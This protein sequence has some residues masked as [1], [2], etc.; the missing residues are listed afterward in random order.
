MNKCT[1]PSQCKFQ[2]QFNQFEF[3]CHLYLLSYSNCS[4][5]YD[6]SLGACLGCRF[7]FVAI[8][9]DNW[10]C[11]CLITIEL[12]VGFFIRANSTFICSQEFATTTL[13][14]GQ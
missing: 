6:S 12:K 4:S 8:K 7:I 14:Q 10:E 5:Y 13:T 2:A 11:D 3:L 1:K 9:E